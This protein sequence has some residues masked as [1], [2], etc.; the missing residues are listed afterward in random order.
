MRNSFVH[1]VLSLLLAI[2]FLF[3]GTG[4][5]LIHYCCTG[6]NESGMMSMSGCSSAD[7]KEDEDSGFNKTPVYYDFQINA[8]NFANHHKNSCEFKRVSVETPTFPNFNINKVNIPFSVHLFAYFVSVNIL[9]APEYVLQPTH[10]P[11]FPFKFSGR[12]ILAQHSILLI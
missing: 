7:N 2:F 3:A 4:Y 1:T 12:E 11:N 6:C 5:N 10:P 9:P 8:Q